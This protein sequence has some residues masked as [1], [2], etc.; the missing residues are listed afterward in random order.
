VL[1]L[2][3]GLHVL[4][5]TRHV[6]GAGFGTS[7][8]PWE[9][10]V[11][12][13]AVI[14][15]YARLVL[16]PWGF[17]IDPDIRVAA[18]QG[19]IGWFLILLIAAVSIRRF[20][21][22]GVWIVSGLILLLPSSS[23]FPAA[24]LAADRR[25]Y[26]PLLA[27]GVALGLLAQKW[28]KEWLVGVA[29]VLVVLS[30]LRT[31]VWR[32]ERA[33]WS[34]AVERSPGKVRPKLQLARVSSPEESVLLLDDAKKLAPNDVAVASQMGS[35]WLAMGKPER[36]LSEFGRALALA[37][38]DPAALN[39]RGVALALLGQSDAA[40][41]DFERALKIDPCLFDA[42]LNLAKLGVREPLPSTCRYTEAQL[43][44]LRS[45]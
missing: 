17:T 3:A 41:Q 29:A 40:R 21:S 4:F 12:Q 20:R 22:V 7:V 2:A 42:R 26:L 1:A 24:D 39:N 27:F 13:G 28:R 25:M 6:V 38:Q 34:E 11:T 44:Q 35:T 43:R 19:W 33:L 32:T 8:S 31:E 37:P 15:R 16:V 23:F 5:A 45:Q 30:V 18:W 10:F 36:A 9:Y 14:L